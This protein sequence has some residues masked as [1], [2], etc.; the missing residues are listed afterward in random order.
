MIR[1]NENLYNVAEGVRMMPS[2][3]PV[4]FALPLQYQNKVPFSANVVPEAAVAPYQH[5]ASQRSTGS[6]SP[7]LR[8]YH[9]HYQLP[10]SAGTAVKSLHSYSLWKMC[11]YMI[12]LQ[13]ISTLVLLMPVYMHL[14]MILSH[15]ASLFF[16]KGGCRVW[17]WCSTLQNLLLGLASGLATTIYL[18]FRVDW[19]I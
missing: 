12:V 6:L 16:R 9:K 3:P 1:W 7:A 14:V 19:C 2:R 10:V 17:G 5:D 4:G 11:I 13:K 8:H 15:E 18:V